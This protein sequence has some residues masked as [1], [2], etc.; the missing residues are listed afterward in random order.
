[1]KAINQ[2]LAVFA[3]ASSFLLAGCKEKAAVASP[4]CAD[5]AKTTDPA[6]KAELLKKC[7]RSG[8]VFTPSEKKEW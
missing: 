2:A 1:M 6:R 8:P 7:P 5:L 4:A 3:L